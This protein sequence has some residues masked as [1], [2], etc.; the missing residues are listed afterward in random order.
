M[1]GG[2]I[3]VGGVLL[4]EAISTYLKAVPFV[5]PF[6]DLATAVIVGTSTAIMSTLAVYLADKADLFGVNRAKVLDQINSEL[7]ASP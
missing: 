2:G 6:A 3:V 1:N 5:A 4:E 7:E